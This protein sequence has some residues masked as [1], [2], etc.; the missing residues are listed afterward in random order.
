MAVSLYLNDTIGF[1]AL[2]GSVGRQDAEAVRTSKKLLDDG[3]AL[4]DELAGL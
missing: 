2:V 1:V 3:E 4:A